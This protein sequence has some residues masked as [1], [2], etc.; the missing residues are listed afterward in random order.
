[1]EP[2]SGGGRSA[3]PGVPRPEGARRVV[4]RG[5]AVWRQQGWR[6]VRRASGVH[7]KPRGLRQEVVTL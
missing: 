6:E 4:N 3:E 7:T 5:R 2:V 1:M